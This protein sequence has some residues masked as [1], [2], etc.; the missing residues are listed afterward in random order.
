M[1]VFDTTALT[2]LNERIA[3][4][5]WLLEAVYHIN[6]NELFPNWRDASDLPDQR[7]TKVFRFWPCQSRHSRLATRL[8]EGGR[9]SRVYHNFQIDR[10]ADRMGFDE[11]RSNHNFSL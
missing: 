7:G 4:E 5:T 9:T 10:H 3:Y 8:F 1:T 11:E 6:L 2:E